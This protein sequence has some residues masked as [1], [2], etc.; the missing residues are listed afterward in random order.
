MRMPLVS[1]VP[2]CGVMMALMMSMVMVF[3]MMRY[4]HRFMMMINTCI[5]VIGRYI[6][7]QLI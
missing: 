4:A 5:I 2:I 6:H 3:L 1:M 7:I